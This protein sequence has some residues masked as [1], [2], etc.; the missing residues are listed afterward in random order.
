[1]PGSGTRGGVLP[2]V[3][4]PVVA[5]PCSSSRTQS[6]PVNIRIQNGE[7][8]SCR[9][10]WPQL[11]EAQPGVSVVFLRAAALRSLPVID[12]HATEL[13]AGRIRSSDSD[14]ARL[15]IG[16]DLDASAYDVVA[17]F[18]DVQTKGTVIDSRIGAHV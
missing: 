13:F 3:A 17:A 11:P 5:H 7:A 8:Q 15:A 6:D 14:S 4:K 9:D 1:M 10:C 12:G 18:S 16:R 2:V